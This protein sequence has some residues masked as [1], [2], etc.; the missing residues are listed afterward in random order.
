M[1]IKE[2]VQEWEGK[3]AEKLTAREYSVRLPVHDAA[4]I[5]ALAEMYPL[6]TESQ[7]ITDLISSALDEL[8]SALP[9]VEGTRVVAEDEEGDPVY[10]D[11][12]PS[13]RLYELT[14]KHLQRLESGG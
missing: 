13:R 14:R 3:A 1:S 2:L 5:A 8:E 10:E 12:G 7:I 11:I 9:Y 4:R 6:R